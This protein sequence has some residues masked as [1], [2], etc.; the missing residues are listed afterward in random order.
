MQ[1][2]YSIGSSIFLQNSLI[3][4]IGETQIGPQK[5]KVK[6]EIFDLRLILILRH[7]V[8]FLYLVKIA[9][10]FFFSDAQLKITE[11]YLSEVKK[12]SL[13]FFLL[14]SYDKFCPSLKYYSR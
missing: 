14:M 5:K 11:G 3:F 10:T 4:T 9:V 8:K 1:A 13:F 7:S 2:C 12:S 6:T